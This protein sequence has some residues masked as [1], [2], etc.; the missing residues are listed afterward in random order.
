MNVHKRCQ[1]NVT[2]NCGIDNKKFG[3]ALN[4]L[5]I[6]DRLSVSGKKKKVSVSESPSKSCSSFSERSHTSPLPNVT[7]QF[8]TFCRDMSNMQLTTKKSYGGSSYSM[9][10]EQRIDQNNIL[11]STSKRRYKLDSFRFIK[12]LGKGSFGKVA[13]IEFFNDLQNQR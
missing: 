3:E 5:G 4:V 10:D 1:K 9:D 6:T 12:V 8:Q 2:N 11:Y 7:D 13:I